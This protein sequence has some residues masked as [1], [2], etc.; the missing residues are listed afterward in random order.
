MKGESWI[1]DQRFG[2]S[3]VGTHRRQKKRVIRV[4]MTDGVQTGYQM[5]KFV[6][7]G[8]FKWSGTRRE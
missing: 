6:G 4:G 1:K 5:G 3:V 8:H 7:D 2:T